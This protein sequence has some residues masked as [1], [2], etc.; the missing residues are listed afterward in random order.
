LQR[1]FGPAGAVRP[2]SDV[3][4]PGPVISTGFPALDEALGVGGLPR[5][6]I[7]DV[8]GP[9]S[10]GKTTLCLHV[11]AAAQQQG[12]QALFIDTENGFDLAYA[13][14]CGIDPDRLFIAQPETA[15]EALEIALVLV[16]AGL[17]LVVIDS[18]AALT[19]RAEVEGEVGLDHG[20]LMACLMSQALSKLIGPLSQNNTL[21][22]LTNQLRLRPDVLVGSR[23]TST[24]GQALRHYAAVRLE[25][26]RIRAIN[27]RDAVV[28]SR[29]RAVVKKN[30]VAPPFR[31]ADIEII[32]GGDR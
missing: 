14:S 15:E 12:G 7:V 8:F 28:G 5:G 20:G 24:G 32:F 4:K 6:R 22:L 19:P 27:H 11:I 21:L 3:L 2:A 30:K 23:E 10:S 25:L 18:V 26:R 9:E 16:R 17:E 31:Q 13:L 29:L 1:R